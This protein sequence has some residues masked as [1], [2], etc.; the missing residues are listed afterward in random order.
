MRTMIINTLGFLMV[1]FVLYLVFKKLKSLLPSFLGCALNNDQSN[2][3]LVRDDVLDDDS[4]DDETHN[5][6]ELDEE[7]I[8]VDDINSDDEIILQ[9]KD[10]EVSDNA[11]DDASD[12]ASDNVSDNVSD[13]NDSVDS[14]E[15]PV[16]EKEVKVVKTK[17]KR[18]KGLKNRKSKTI[19]I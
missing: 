17:E 15:T 16:I 13:D 4:G 10:N 3:T 6:I 2:P 1:V 19:K 8:D 14:V 18:H 11:S 12:D 5:I 9:Q 7:D